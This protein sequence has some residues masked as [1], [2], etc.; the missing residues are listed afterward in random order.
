M[1]L[2]DQK[3]ENLELSKLTAISPVDGRYFLKAGK[4]RLLFSEYGLIK[5]RLIV[6]IKWLSYLAQ[7]KKI[8]K[9]INLT[10]IQKELD[11]VLKKFDVMEAEKIKIIERQTNHDVKAIEYYIKNVLNS[12]PKLRP[13][14]NYIHFGCTSEDINNLAYG[15]IMGEAREAVMLPE[16]EELLNELKKIA[17]DSADIAMISRTHG[18]AATP[19]TL[20]KEVANFYHRLE[21]QKTHWKDVAISGKLN[22]AVGNF[23]AFVCAFP[24]IN[25][26]KKNKLF[27]EQLG[28]EFNKYSTQIEPHDCIARYTN[29]LG[30][31]NSILIDFCRDIWTYISLDYF[32]QKIK[33]SEVGS[34]TMPHKVNPID[35]ENAEGNCGVSN[36]LLKHFA[37]KLVISR[38]QRD[39][40][41]STVLR[42]V[43][44]AVAHTYLAI[45]SIRA[46]LEKLQINYT[47]IEEDLAEEWQL[48]TEPIQT[49]LRANGIEDAY[50]KLKAMSRGKKI[51]QQELLL[52]VEGL[53]LPDETI[54]KLKAL[55]PSSYIGLASKLAREI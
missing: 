10:E 22:G 49:I 39:L 24:S 13:L 38:L 32:K 4:L 26:E 1:Q 11:L 33:E 46:G 23:N 41:D 29:E 34:S 20:G 12:K 9:N 55:T 42:N 19:T 50:E 44:V 54:N 16:I 31:I 8:V 2:N 6:E 51:T 53:N 43:G 36:S 3:N 7:D 18:Q 48:L 14:T 45:K 5:Y 37:E 27:V 21:K 17:H 52:F 30:L 47:I 35:F 15:L 28:L 25:W 40:S